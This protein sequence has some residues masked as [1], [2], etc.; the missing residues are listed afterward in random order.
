MSVVN[1]SS[2][3]SNAIHMGCEKLNNKKSCVYFIVK[4]PFDFIVVVTCGADLITYYNKQHT[5]I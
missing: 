5:F 1:D 4:Y 2:S 3:E